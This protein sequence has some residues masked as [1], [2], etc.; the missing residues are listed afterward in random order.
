MKITE[1]YL[2]NKCQFVNTINNTILV[3]MFIDERL[4]Y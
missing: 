1:I 2:N 3:N 4:N